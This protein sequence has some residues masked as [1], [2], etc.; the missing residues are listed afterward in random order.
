MG[1]AAAPVAVLWLSGVYLQ[2]SNLSAIIAAQVAWGALAAGLMLS[3]RGWTDGGSQRMFR[4]ER[5]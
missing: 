4:G 3:G 2:R 5:V 1:C